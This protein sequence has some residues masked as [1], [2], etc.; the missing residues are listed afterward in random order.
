MR[1]LGLNPTES[2]VQ[3]IVNEVDINGNG[4][5]DF[6]EFL[7]VMTKKMEEETDVEEIREAFRV[8]DKFGQ[9]YI[10]NSVLHHVLVSLGIDKDEVAE[11][12]N[13]ADIDGDGKIEYEEFVQVMTLE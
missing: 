3:E 10:E 9:G 1:S 2:E 4:K 6:S 7:M 11:F 13:D 12:V 8:F 5:I